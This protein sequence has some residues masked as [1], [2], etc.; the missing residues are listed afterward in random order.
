MTS[1]VTNKEPSPDLKPP[2]PDSGSRPTLTKIKEDDSILKVH[3]TNQTDDSSILGTGGGFHTG[4][5]HGG[6]KAEPLKI[7]GNDAALGQD[8]L[9]K[10]SGGPTGKLTSGLGS[11]HR[12]AE[13]QNSNGP[14]KDESNERKKD[15]NSILAE[16]SD[17]KNQ[18]TNS[19]KS[20][21]AELLLNAPAKPSSP[22]TSTGDA[23]ERST[24]VKTSEE[25]LAARKDGANV[26]FSHT[27][28]Y[29]LRGR[30]KNQVKVAVDPSS[31]KKN[32]SGEERDSSVI[33]EINSPR[34][35]H[36]DTIGKAV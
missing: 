1:N 24:S 9:G 27:H 7:L 29:A 30:G 15:S 21:L 31:D 35:A 14:F 32:R 18:A 2:L 36:D 11:K 28:K 26:G 20:L 13:L 16:G 19:K 34:T 8:T 22:V 25:N 5:D 6:L 33:K 17:T 23:P 4:R 3:S 10:D 12:P